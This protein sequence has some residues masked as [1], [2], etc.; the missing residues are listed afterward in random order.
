M[1]RRLVGWGQDKGAL[2]YDRKLGVMVQLSDLYD[3]YPVISDQA[4]DWLFQPNPNASNQFAGT[5]LRQV[6]VGDLP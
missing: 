6:N 2:V 3:F 5:V 1:N 4:L